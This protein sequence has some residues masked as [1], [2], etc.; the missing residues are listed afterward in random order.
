VIL[1]WSQFLIPFLLLNKDAQLPISVAIFNFSG[2]SERLDDPGAG[3]RVSCR[4]GAGHR[5][6]PASAAHDRRRAYRRRRQ[7]LIRF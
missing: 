3:R 5:R 6:L 1:N 2:T 4:R 7:G